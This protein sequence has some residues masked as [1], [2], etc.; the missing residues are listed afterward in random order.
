M[1][2]PTQGHGERF[3]QS[4]AQLGVWLVLSAVV[5]DHRKDRPFFNYNLGP[6]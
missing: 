4:V 1:T 5:I 3:A 6:L 2:R